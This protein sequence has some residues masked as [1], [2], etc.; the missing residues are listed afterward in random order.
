LLEDAFRELS[1]TRA[2]YDKT[3]HSVAITEWLIANQPA[4]LDE[5][6]EFLIP[7][8]PPLEE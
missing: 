6:A 2:S 7:L 4:A 3:T 1:E 5:I 8:L